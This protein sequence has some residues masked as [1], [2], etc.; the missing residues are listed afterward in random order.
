MTYKRIS[1]VISGKRVDGSMY[2][3]GIPSNL[4]YYRTD[5][6]SKEEDELSEE[7]IQ[8]FAEMIQLQYGVKIDDHKFV[9]IMDDE[10]DAFENEFDKYKDLVTVFINQDVLLSTSQEKLLQ[11]VNTYIIPDSYFDSELREAGELW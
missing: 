10:M 11:K 7:L 2:S 1:T 3:E 8:H 6:I 4:K 5:F 9:M